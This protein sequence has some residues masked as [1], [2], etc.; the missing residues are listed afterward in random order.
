MNM[1]PVS[2]S[3]ISEV[4]YD[5]D[6]QT[7]RVKFKSGGEYDYSGVSAEEHE[8][9]L[10]APSIGKHFLSSIKPSKPCSKCE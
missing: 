5:P 7:L 4:G 10:S 8:A 2:S 9:L 6:T 1:K 3:N